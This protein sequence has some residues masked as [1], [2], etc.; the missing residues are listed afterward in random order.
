MTHNISAIIIP[1]T[2]WRFGV[3]DALLKKRTDIREEKRKKG[4]IENKV[5]IMFPA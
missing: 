2:I 5:R 1:N 3:W 4:R